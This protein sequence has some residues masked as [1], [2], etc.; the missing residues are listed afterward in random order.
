MSEFLLE[1]C[2]TCIHSKV[3]KYKS[4]FEQIIEAGLVPL[5]SESFPICAEYVTDVDGAEWG[6]EISPDISDDDVRE[7][8]ESRD[9]DSLQEEIRSIIA[10]HIGECLESERYPEEIAMS[11]ETLGFLG[12]FDLDRVE[13]AP[14]TWLDLRIDDEIPVGQFEITGTLDDDDED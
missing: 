11:S 6:M 3:C 7:W 8:F 14:N 4:R 13:A 5:N 12:W 1:E 2:G 9:P 10:D